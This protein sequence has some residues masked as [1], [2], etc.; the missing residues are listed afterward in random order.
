MA[1]E[2]D[3]ISKKKNISTITSAT[4]FRKL[5]EYETEI[6]RLE[7]HENLDKKSKSIALKVDSK[8]VKKEENP[9]EEEN[10]ML[11]VKRL[12]K[13]YGTNENSNFSRKKKYFNK[14]EASTST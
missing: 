8:E 14:K 12:G 11:L 5:Q 10:S 6:G 2:S 1:T 3:T 4:L 13:Y 7:K 9:E